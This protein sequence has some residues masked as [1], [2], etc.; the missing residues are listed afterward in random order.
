MRERENI[1]RTE[2]GMEKNMRIDTEDFKAGPWEYDER[3]G[4]WFSE[5]MELTGGRWE[6]FV[7][8]RGRI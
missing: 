6:G 7:T 2:G 3:R 4:I 8:T 1:N 5:C